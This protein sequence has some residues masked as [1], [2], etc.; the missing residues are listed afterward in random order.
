MRALRS[1]RALEPIIAS[2]IAISFISLTPALAKEKERVAVLD[3]KNRAGVK[4]G[5]V[6]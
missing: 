6:S 3:L 5:E 4:A 1:S 2:L